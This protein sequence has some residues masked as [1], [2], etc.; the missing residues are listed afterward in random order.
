MRVHLC[1]HPDNCDYC[2]RRAELEAEDL[3]SA[4]EL[5]DL[6]DYAA[7]HEYGGGHP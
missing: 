6:A 4:H 2:E 1:R 7:A 5:D 3:Y